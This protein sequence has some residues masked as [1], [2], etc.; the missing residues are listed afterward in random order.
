MRKQKITVLFF[1]AA[2]MIVLFALLPRLI[3][4]TLDWKLSKTHTYSDMRS[5]QLNMVTQQNF[6]P[7]DKLA[8]LSA[9]EI[10]NTTQDRMT[11]DENKV[12]EIVSAFM[13]QCEA[14]GIL[15][16]FAPS[17]VS[18]QPKLLYDLSDPATHLLVWTV[19]MLYEAD[20]NQVLLMDVDDETGKILCF[21]YNIYQKYSMDGIWEQNKAIMDAI[22]H[23]YF[24]QFGLTDYATELQN[25]PSVN[26]NTDAGTSYEYK[27]VDGGVTEVIYTFDT[28]SFGQYHF[29]FTVDGAGGFT[30]TIYK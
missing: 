30:L 17:T 25:A 4:S 3:V 8:F 24:D 5:I 29:Q 26:G 9:A 12:M 11:M 16:W 14:T 20:P 15:Q 1:G 22:T 28:P 23:I 2:A 7:L 21:S 18:I 27:E 10:A 6:S 13:R 19:T